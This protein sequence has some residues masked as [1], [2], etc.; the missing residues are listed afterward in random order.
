MPNKNAC[1][2][3]KSNNSVEGT[4]VFI[5]PVQPESHHL[6]THTQS[7]ATNVHHTHIQALHKAACINNRIYIEKECWEGMKKNV[8]RREEGRGRGRFHLAGL[9]EGWG[10][11]PCHAR[12]FVK[13]KLHV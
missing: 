2:R 3:R 10:R 13:G 9:D 11:K 6:S 12:A 7:A 5:H 1:K 4:A 8:G